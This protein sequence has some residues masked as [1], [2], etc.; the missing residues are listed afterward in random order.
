LRAVWRWTGSV[1]PRRE[2]TPNSLEAGPTLDHSGWTEREPSGCNSRRLH[3]TWWLI[4]TDEVRGYTA[5][6]GEIAHSR[7]RVVFPGGQENGCIDV[8][9]AAKQNG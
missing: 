7:N 8:T 4:E 6:G 2:T 3:S 9:T 1:A 5:P